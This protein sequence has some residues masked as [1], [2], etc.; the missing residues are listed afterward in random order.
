MH[1]FT[2]VVV[3]LYDNQ[4]PGGHNNSTFS[5]PF[6]FMCHMKYDEFEKRHQT[7]ETESKR[8][9]IDAMSVK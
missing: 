9:V 8:V 5:L 4:R 1:F 6:Y 7:T 3:I 2:L